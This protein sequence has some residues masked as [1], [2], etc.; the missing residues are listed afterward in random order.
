MKVGLSTQ[1]SQL[2]QQMRLLPLLAPQSVQTQNPRQPTTV[3][4]TTLKEILSKGISDA[5]LWADL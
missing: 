2:S 1:G 4:G 5:Q 3:P